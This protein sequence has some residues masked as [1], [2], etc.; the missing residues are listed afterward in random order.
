MSPQWSQLLQTTNIPYCE[1]HTLVLDRLDIESYYV[2]KGNISTYHKI[3]DTAVSV[4]H[5][6]VA[7]LKPILHFD[8]CGWRSAH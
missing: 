3:N 6:R 2:H 1:L 8:R 7:L 5:S 4:F